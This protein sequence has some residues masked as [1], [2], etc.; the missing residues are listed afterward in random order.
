MNLEDTLQAA[1]NAG[2][3]FSGSKAFIGAPEATIVKT[4]PKERIFCL[5][6]GA[7]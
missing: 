6:E 5:G 4:T 3:T 2:L 1:T 7:I